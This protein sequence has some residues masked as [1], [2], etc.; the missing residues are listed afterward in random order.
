MTKSTKPKGFTCKG[1]GTEHVFPLYVYA[2]W[3]ESLLFTCPKCSLQ[4]NVRAGVAAA[5]RKRKR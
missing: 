4:Y 5:V 1:C 2:H 3:N